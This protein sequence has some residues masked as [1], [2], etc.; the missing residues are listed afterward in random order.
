[1][2]SMSLKSCLTSVWW[3][4]VGCNG[5]VRVGSVGRSAA[6]YQA[7]PCL[8]DKW[9]ISRSTFGVHQ[10]GHASPILSLLAAVAPCVHI[11]SVFPTCAGAYLLTPLRTRPY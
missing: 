3:C 7:V 5:S 2:A 8:Y 11:Y 6:L 10:V 4:T 1:M 9:S